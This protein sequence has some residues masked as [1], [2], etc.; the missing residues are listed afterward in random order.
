MP[1]GDVLADELARLGEGLIEFSYIFASAA[2][3]VGTPTA[4]A[5]HNWRDGLNELSRLNLL[6]QF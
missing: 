5:A 4:F 6:R 2:G 3:V 1:R